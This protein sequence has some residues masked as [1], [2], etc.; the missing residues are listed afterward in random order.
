[1]KHIVGMMHGLPDLHGGGAGH[2]QP[3]GGPS[4]I[5]EETS[6]GMLRAANNT[7]ERMTHQ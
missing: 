6:F 7:S 2:G 3:R 1:M 5:C 4:M